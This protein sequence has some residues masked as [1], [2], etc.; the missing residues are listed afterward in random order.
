MLKR[1]FANGEA[2]RYKCLS[3]L[4][5]TSA[6]KFTNERSFFLKRALVCKLRIIFLHDGCAIQKDKDYWRGCLYS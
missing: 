4:K 1:L 5:R 3:V 2:F 6:Q